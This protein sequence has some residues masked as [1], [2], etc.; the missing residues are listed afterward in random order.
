LNDL[1]T[2][3]GGNA[4]AAPA[5][6]TS[7]TPARLTVFAGPTSVGKG[8][9][10]SRLR[11]LYPEVWVSVSATTRSRRP[12]EVD[13]VHYQFVTPAE[14]AEMQTEGQ[15]L[16]WAQVHGLNYYGTPKAPV[17]NRLES[18]QPVVLEIDLDGAR[19]VRQ[20]MPDALFIFLAPPSFSELERR[21][22]KRGTEST[23]E[24]AR[25]LQTARL[26]LAAASEFDAVIVNDAVD[27]AVAE[28]AQLMGLA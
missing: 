23:A 7:E 6:T 2:N 24:Q 22:V 12:G 27:D 18:G 15:L 25:R 10:V 14:F 11:E 26:E 4:G 3:S 21:L 17:L 16:E 19:Q 5:V 9:V 13:G 20:T 1:T 28:L 8:T